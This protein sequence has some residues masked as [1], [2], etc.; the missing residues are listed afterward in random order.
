MPS[1]RAQKKL[2]YYHTKHVTT[3]R[4][5]VLYVG[6]FCVLGRLRDDKKCSEINKNYHF[7]DLLFSWR[8]HERQAVTHTHKNEQIWKLLANCTQRNLLKQQNKHVIGQFLAV[9]ARTEETSPLLY[10]T[11]DHLKIFLFC[12]LQ[13]SASWE[14]CGMIKKCFEI[15]K[16]Y[17]FQDLLF[18]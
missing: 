8:H 10:Q 3:I 7:Q 1:W 11:R 14:D 16:N 5:F 18:S 12:M 6:I 17:N 15:N 2:H 9:M 13:S 4:F